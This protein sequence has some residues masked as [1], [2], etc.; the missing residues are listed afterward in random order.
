MIDEPTFEKL[1]AKAVS[2]LKTRDQLDNAAYLALLEQAVFDAEWYLSDPIAA[3]R[4]DPRGSRKT[5][6]MRVA[7]TIRRMQVKRHKKD[8]WDE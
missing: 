7:D 5:N 8:P 6:I 2:D 3:T 4:S 1:I